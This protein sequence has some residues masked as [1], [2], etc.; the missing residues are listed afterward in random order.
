MV[1]PAIAQQLKSG[2][3]VE[4]QY[5]SSATM[6]YIDV[7]DFMKATRSIQAQHAAS[8]I[9]E[10]LRYPLPSDYSIAF[11]TVAFHV[12][13]GNKIK[14]CIFYRCTNTFNF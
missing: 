11:L 9:S 5:F 4:P 3:Q 1:P 13:Y 10:L 6:C 14:E 8:F 12:K 2:H 7:V